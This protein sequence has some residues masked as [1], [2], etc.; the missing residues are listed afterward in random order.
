MTQA[1][2]TSGERTG[3]GA[4]RSPAR[5]ADGP[6]SHDHDAPLFAA[7]DLG[8][9]NCRLLIASP[10]GRSFRVVEAFSRIVRLGEGLSR[11]GQLDPAA[12]DRAIG[13]LQV[14]AEKVRRR[15][16]LRIRAVATQAWRVLGVSCRTHHPALSRRH[17]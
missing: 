7:I 13:A 2:R 8:T 9:N 1:Q 3:D 17:P 16:P 12:M 4:P 5:A 10:S 15:K 14:C 11:T 6:V